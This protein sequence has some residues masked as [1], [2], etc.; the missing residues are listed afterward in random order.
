MRRKT[1]NAT[2]SVQGTE[3]AVIQH[4]D[5]DFISL[6]DMVGNFDGG[7]ALIEQWLK[8]KDTRVLQ[9]IATCP[10]TTHSAPARSSPP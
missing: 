2:I 4:E 3:I 10:S 6:T 7:P 5:D 1:A 8:N 9:S